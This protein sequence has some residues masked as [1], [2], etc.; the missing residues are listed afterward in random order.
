MSTERTPET[1]LTD[2]QTFACLLK[3]FWSELL[4]DEMAA[5]IAKQAA[6]WFQPVGTMESK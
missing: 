3:T 2:E 4:N 1:E 6:D 5:I